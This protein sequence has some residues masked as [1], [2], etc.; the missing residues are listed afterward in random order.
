MFK[1]I[2]LAKKVDSDSNLGVEFETSMCD[3]TKTES[4]AIYNNNTYFYIDL[5]LKPLFFSF[6]QN[7]H[8]VI[9]Y[10]AVSTMPKS[11]L[12]QDRGYYLAVFHSSSTLHYSY[13]GI[14]QSPKWILSYQGESHSNPDKTE[15]ETT[16]GLL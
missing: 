7:H 8:G 12:L 2:Y 6:I 15:V 5:T 14:H 13:K 9:L 11:S 1:S 10:T 16:D 3:G 4:L